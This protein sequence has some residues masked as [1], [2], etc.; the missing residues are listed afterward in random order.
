MTKT[1]KCMIAEQV[2]EALLG[3]A[4]G[5]IIQKTVIPKCNKGEQ[6]LVTLGAAVGGWMLGR[7]FGNMFYKFC[8]DVFDTGFNDNE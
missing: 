6:I 1:E 2:G 7:T 3:A 5:I 8:D 4:S